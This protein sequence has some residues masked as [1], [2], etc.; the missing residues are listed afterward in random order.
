MRQYIATPSPSELRAHQIA[1]YT[2]LLNDCK[3][4]GQ[5]RFLRTQLYNLKKVDH[6]NVNHPCPCGNV[7]RVPVFNNQ[8]LSLN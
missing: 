3:S 7:S 5:K 2:M 1:Y 4:D 8:V 6:G